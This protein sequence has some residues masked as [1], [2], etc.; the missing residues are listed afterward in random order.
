MKKSTVL[1]LLVFVL[2]MGSLF[3]QDEVITIDATG[4]TIDQIIRD[5]LLD[6]KDYHGK[7]ISITN[8]TFFR[9]GTAM[10][11]GYAYSPLGSGNIGGALERWFR[12]DETYRIVE[13][14]GNATNQSEAPY[15]YFF[16][17]PAD[18][19]GRRLMLDLAGKYRTVPV[20]L[21]INGIYNRVQ[22]GSL[23]F[24]PFY[25]TSFILNGVEYKGNLP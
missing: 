20:K 14:Q 13:R 7:R 19:E 5:I 2:A 21:T 12:S 4:K 22:N 9:F 17:Q 11:T 6:W 18:R 15:F 24:N 23:T 1:L 10:D 25:V 3:A 16:F 8:L